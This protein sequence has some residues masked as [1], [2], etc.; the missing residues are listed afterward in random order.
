[1]ENYFKP[2][3]TSFSFPSFKLNLNPF[4]KKQTKVSSESTSSTKK[5]FKFPFKIVLSVLGGFLV[6][7]ILVLVGLYFY[8]GQSLMAVYA[9]GIDLKQ[10]SFVFR[11]SLKEQDLDKISTSLTKFDTDFKSFKE[12]YNQNESKL[13]SLP[14]FSDY[15]QDV[16]H[17]LQ[18]GEDSIQLGF[19][20]LN[21][22]DP[23]AAELGL[24][25]GATAL[26]NEERI[27]QIAMILPKFGP[28]VE[29][30]SGLL[31]KI[32]TE[33]SLVDETKYPEEF[34][35]IKVKSQI[36]SIK[37]VFSQLAQKSPKFKGLFEQLPYLVGVD[38]KRTYLVLMANST[39]IRMSGGFTTYSIIVEVENGVPKVLTGVDTFDVDADIS[40]LVYP[41]YAGGPYGFL[42]SYLLVPRLYARDA[43]STTPDFRS[44]VELFM[45][46]FWKK[47]PCGKRLGCLNKNID[48]V[49]QVNTHLAE[50][51]LAVTGP[52]DV[53]GRAFKTDQGTYKGFA[54]AVFTNENV[55][56]QLEKIANADLAEIQGR[57]E[58]IKYLLQS[59]IEKVLN[60]KTEN[61]AS[62]V[63]VFLES[64]ASKDLLVYSMNVPT[65][66]ALE[67]LGYAGRVSYTDTASDFIF[68]AH[69]NFGAGKR[70][71]IITR[72]TSKEVFERDG[73]VISK[74][75][76]KITNP[77]SPDWWQSSWLYTYKDYLRLYVPKG[78][79]L[80]S[81]TASD[82]QNIDSKAV[83]D[84]EFANLEFFSVFFRTDV[85]KDTTVTFEYELPATISLQNYK[86]Q[87]H[88]QSGV[89]NDLYDV[90]KGDVK[91][92]FT[93]NE[94][95]LL[96]F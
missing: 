62:I 77:K 25:K 90:T 29:K 4:K 61:L 63:S 7:V 71:W 84:K 55:I 52:I 38:G 37:T 21:T 75:S 58:I 67:E 22:L 8:V 34:R 72:E 79:K 1:M 51:L 39:E 41:I 94:D 80:I 26:K 14:Y 13:S 65:Q 45:T 32:N 59:M 73:K 76:V 88:K 31:N 43:L 82:G 10:S 83:L 6:I 40:S 42:R 87:I 33:L 89:H 70:D 95:T 3:K 17:F 60:T 5:K 91:K 27:K 64:L 46:K 48:G 69:S 50:S 49:I 85:E 78:S 86:L 81:A 93:L 56:Y 96:S 24:K 16:T 74:V 92:V 23:Y 57:K 30:M 18:A 36:V 66:T 35:G 44:G 2:K 47:H 20:V 28:E 15:A 9:A 53:G 11:E 12:V 54:D 19:L 68:L